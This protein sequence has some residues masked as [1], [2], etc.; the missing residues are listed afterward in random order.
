MILLVI[1]EKSFIGAKMLSNINGR[2]CK[3]DL[4]LFFIQ[5]FS[6]KLSLLKKRLKN[7]TKNDHLRI[8]F[9]NN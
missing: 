3:N 6:K 8:I 1:D 7:E 2:L 5:L 4:R 9:K